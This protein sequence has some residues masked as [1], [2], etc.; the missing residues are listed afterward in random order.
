MDYVRPYV[1]MNHFA[2][3]LLVARG[4]SVL[5]HKAFGLADRTFD[6]PFTTDT[7]LRV[8]SITKDFTASLILAL[9]DQG[10]LALDDPLARHLPEFPAGDRITIEQ[11]LVHTH[12][13]PSWRG[14]PDAATMEAVGPTLAEAV[15]RLAREPLQ[16]EPGSE[17]RYGSSGH[18]LLARVVEVVT[19][20]SYAEAL[21][22][23]VLDPL[24][25]A[26]TGSLAGLEVVPRLAESYVPTG[27]PPWLRLP[28]AENPAIT[29]GSASAWSTARDLFRYARA[30]RTAEA[31]RLGWGDATQHGHAL[32]WT[33][34]MT[35]GFVA[36]IHVFPD[37]E[38]TLVLLGNVFTPVFR[39]ILED[40]AA[41][42]FGDR[43]EPPPVWR[44]VTLTA[45]QRTAFT[46]TWTCGDG[47]SFKIREAPGDGELTFVFSS[48]ARFP[49]VPRSPRVLHLP[50]DYATVRF[51]EPSADGFRAA[52][53]E[54]G[55]DADCQRSG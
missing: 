14:L 48:D 51:D 25:L 31:R 26:D 16:F 41:M 39:V 45:T 42:A 5:V 36:R 38:L 44:P 4:D 46:G 27:S 9:R 15:A 8:G 37:E 53:F 30:P 6:V 11:L 1:T 40:L 47:F 23:L 22:S 17:R 50:T 2:G 29:V 55:F 10:R 54:G 18:L 34:G 19:G 21:G 33:S 20:E 12:G 7:R 32:R 52:R 24:G 28:G 35:D 13:V 49:L 43:V 3:T